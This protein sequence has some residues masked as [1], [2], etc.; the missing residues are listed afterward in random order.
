[1]L[2]CLDIRKPIATG[3]ER[4]GKPKHCCR[5]DLAATAFGDDDLQSLLGLVSTLLHVCK[6]PQQYL[7]IAGDD[8][9]GA[10]INMRVLGPYPLDF[11]EGIAKR[12]SEVREVVT[13][14]P[15]RP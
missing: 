12:R 2:G 1:M 3:C 10:A 11:E 9:A 8:E 7:F 4:R 13:E 15:S 5:E 6:T 14:V